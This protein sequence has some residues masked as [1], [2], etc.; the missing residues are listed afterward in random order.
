[1]FSVFETPNKTVIL[2]ACDCFDLFVFSAL[3]TGCYF[4]FSTP[5]NK[6]VILSEAP[7]RSI[8]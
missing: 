4:C 6:T 7:R 2:R 3:L 5:Q 8:A 1:M